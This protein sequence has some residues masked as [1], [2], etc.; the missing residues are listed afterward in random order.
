MANSQ[1]A[2]SL[3]GTN[4]P[5]PWDPQ[6]NVGDQPLDIWTRLPSAPATQPSI[7]VAVEPDRTDIS[8]VL[9]AWRAAERQLDEHVEASPMRALLQ[10][11][12]ARWRAEYQR[13]FV[14][15]AR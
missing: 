1:L 3:G 10:S 14:L 2:P 9:S 7:A 12:I 8:H 13:L 6:G 15:K 4:G 5:A 11:E